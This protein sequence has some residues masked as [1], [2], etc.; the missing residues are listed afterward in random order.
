MSISSDN[1]LY[2][3]NESIIFNSN[4]SSPMNTKKGTNEEDNLLK[5]VLKDNK[6]NSSYISTS[7]LYQPQPRNI[8][9]IPIDNLEYSQ[10]EYDIQTP[11]KISK[12]R[13]NELLANSEKAIEEGDELINTQYISYSNL[14]SRIIKFI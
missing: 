10:N 9:P 4:P 11:E 8:K 14:S 12:F 5:Q 7:P 3:S 13:I 1:E 6:N 2:Q